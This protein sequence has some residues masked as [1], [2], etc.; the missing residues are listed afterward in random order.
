MNQKKA[1]S[2]RRTM[3]RLFG[4][5]P[6]EVVEQPKKPIMGM[7]GGTFNV[8]TRKMEGATPWVIFSGVNALVPSCGRAK[9]QSLKRDEKQYRRQGKHTLGPS[10]EYFPAELDGALG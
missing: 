5:D 3:K 2:I 7:R 1:K 8:I 9:Y 6:R 10:H 4:R